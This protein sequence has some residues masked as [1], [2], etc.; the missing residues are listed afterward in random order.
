MPYVYHR[1]PSSPVGQMLEPLNRLKETQPELYAQHTRKY[2][3]REWLLQRQIERL[4]CLWNDVIHTSPVPPQRVYAALRQAG[5][6]KRFPTAWYRI[7][8][9]TMGF[10][11]ANTV[12]YYSGSHP[13]QARFEPFAIEKL[14]DMDTLPAAT[15]AYYRQQ[16]EA[17]AAPLL[18]HQVPHILHRGALPI[19]ALET[20]RV[21]VVS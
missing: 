14:A 12:I 3:G 7:D 16:I 13:S 11:E 15:F 19:D 1:V 21:D 8:V 4:G 20:I 9:V 5:W 18:F 10:S 17:G 6:Q 2:Q